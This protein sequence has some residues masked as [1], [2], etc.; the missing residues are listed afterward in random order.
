[1]P[2][3]SHAAT[4]YVSVVMPGSW[5]AWG[6]R[7]DVS[8]LQ[9]VARLQTSWCSRLYMPVFSSRAVPVLRRHMPV[10]LIH[11]QNNNKQIVSGAPGRPG[12]QLLTLHGEHVHPSL[13]PK[14]SRVAHQSN[15]LVLHF[16]DT[17]ALIAI[18]QGCRGWR[19]LEATNENPCS[20]IPETTALCL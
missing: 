7:S 6:F 18:W 4:L 11:I 1:M 19:C 2:Q 14:P 12:T 3:Q 15:A 9:R 17:A 10:H 8:R 5:A 20:C 16:T 13:P